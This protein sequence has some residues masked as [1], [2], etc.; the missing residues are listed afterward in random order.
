MYG[1]YAPMH[2]AASHVIFNSSPANVPDAEGVC[3][4]PS[5]G[6]P[7]HQAPPAVHSERVHLRVPAV[8]VEP[9][10]RAAHCTTMYEPL[11]GGGRGGWHAVNSAPARSAMAASRVWVLPTIFETRA[12]IMPSAPRPSPSCK[13]AG[14]A[15]KGDR[16]IVGTRL[17]RR[18]R[19]VAQA[20]PWVELSHGVVPVMRGF[21]PLA[22]STPYR[23]R[24]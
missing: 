23:H 10:V 3:Q 13:T 21:G 16:S 5:A 6:A 9:P 7:P 4:A 19:V 17:R 18:V 24:K 11:G 22:Q 2:D 14:R 20:W 1:S 8:G 12:A 15:R